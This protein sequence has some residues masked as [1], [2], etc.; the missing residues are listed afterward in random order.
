MGTGGMTK[1]RASIAN[2]V[3][4]ALKLQKHCINVPGFIASIK[5]SEGDALLSKNAIRE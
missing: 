2:C 3:N 4:V 5:A 1:R